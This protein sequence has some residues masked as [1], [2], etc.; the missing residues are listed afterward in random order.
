LLRAG[1]RGSLPPEYAAVERRVHEAMTAYRIRNAIIHC[2][3]P[4]AALFPDAVHATTR[5]RSPGGSRSGW[6]GA[7]AACCPG[8]AWAP[9]TARG[10][11]ASHSPSRWQAAPTCGP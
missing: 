4:R 2:F 10:G 3:D 11:R 7:D 8:T 1:A 5:V 9:W 6:S